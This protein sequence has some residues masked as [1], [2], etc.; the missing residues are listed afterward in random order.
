M[1]STANSS[2]ATVEAGSCQTL[3]SF[4]A[5]FCSEGKRNK[6]DLPLPQSQLVAVGF[7]KSV[8]IL[9]GPTAEAA[10]ACSMPW[11]AESLES[12]RGIP[13]RRPLS[14]LAVRPTRWIYESTESGQSTWTT[15]STAGKSTPGRLGE[16][17]CAGSGCNFQLCHPVQNSSNH[18]R[19]FAV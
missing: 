7:R 3:E 17:G 12:P 2:N 18:A 11:H 1:S 16:K 10:M 5:K 6:A 19:Q 13:Q 4:C 8:K 14:Y 9:P 15:Q